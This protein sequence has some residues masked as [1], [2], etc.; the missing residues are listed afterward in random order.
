MKGQQA[1]LAFN[2]GIVPAG[3]IAI[4]GLSKSLLVV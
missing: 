4:H 3:N 2:R 1:S